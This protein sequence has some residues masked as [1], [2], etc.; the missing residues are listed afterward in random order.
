[1]NPTSESPTWLYEQRYNIGKHRRQSSLTWQVKLSLGTQI[2][3]MTLMCSLCSGFVSPPTPSRCFVVPLQKLCS[4]GNEEEEESDQYFRFEV[5]WVMSFLFLRA[6]YCSVSVHLFPPSLFVSRHLY[7]HE[8]HNLFPVNWLNM[9]FIKCQQ[10]GM[11]VKSSQSS[12]WCFQNHQ[13]ETQRRL[14]YGQTQRSHK[15]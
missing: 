14:V 13:S 11:P 15:K 3:R 10:W 5:K 2:P 7:L 4:H 12:W 6:D 9:R 1:M 8:G